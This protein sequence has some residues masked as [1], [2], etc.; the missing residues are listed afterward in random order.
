VEK[1]AL[2]PYF[3][4]ERIEFLKTAPK[5]LKKANKAEDT[6]VERPAV[7]CHDLAGLVERVADARGLKRK[8]LPKVGLDSGRG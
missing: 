1:R 5:K 2:E 4:K 7:Y 6:M 8:A 3:T